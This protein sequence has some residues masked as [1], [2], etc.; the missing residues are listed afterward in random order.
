MRRHFLLGAQPL[1]LTRAMS[2]FCGNKR[3]LLPLSSPPVDL[4]ALHA[5]QTSGKGLSLPPSILGSTLMGP[6]VVPFLHK[7]QISQGIRR[8]PQG[9]SVNSPILS[10]S[11]RDCISKASA[12]LGRILKDRPVHCAH[13]RNA[14]RR[15]KGLSCRRQQKMGGHNANYIRIRPLYQIG[16]P[17]SQ[18]FL[19]SV[20]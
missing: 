6:S 19:T 4:I 7:I 5:F 3:K 10:P 8:T 11:S 12:A 16:S 13:C 18:A 9:G 15:H 2:Q 14:T 17:S 20:T 1:S